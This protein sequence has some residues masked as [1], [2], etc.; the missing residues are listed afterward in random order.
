MKR[1][2]FLSLLV[3]VGSASFSGIMAQSEGS[4]QDASMIS[5]LEL[6]DWI[7]LAFAGV[8]LLIIFILANTLH[9][10]MSKP[11]SE[12]IKNSGDKSKFVTILG[13]VFFTG[14]CAVDANAENEGMNPLLSPVRLVVYLVL[15]IEL[16]AI[17]VL[18]NWIKYFTGIKDYQEKENALKEKKVWSFSGFWHK[19]NRFKSAEEEASLDIGH[20][21]DGIRE[22]DNATPP[23]FTVSFI[24]TIIFAF[25]YMYR[26]HVAYSAPN[27]MQEYKMEV[28][29]A[30][31]EQ[32]AYL[33]SQ[34]NLVDETNV[35][36]LDGSGI[37][38][39][40][41]LYASNCVACHGANG[42]GG[43]GPNLTDDYWLH[44]GKIN[45]IFKVIKYGV[46]D[47]GM[48]SWQEDFSPNQIAQLA[49]FIKSIHGTNP[50]GAKEKQGEKYVETPTGT[51]NQGT[52]DSTAIK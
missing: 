14:M 33:A 49:S 3:S 1:N 8:L 15:L 5:A 34:G 23:W 32:K 39:G 2:I 9:L 19:F 16:I 43:V 24:A 45:D 17:V 46:L 6:Y 11:L 4:R 42:E 40:K 7:L 41:G 37:S 51:D 26:Y 36:M 10:A 25:V 29:K 18:I 48:K 38:A 30:L 28:S 35:T 44:G 22:L 27:Q 20:S 47:K 50:P 52:P 12:K 13:I 31:A 21:Y